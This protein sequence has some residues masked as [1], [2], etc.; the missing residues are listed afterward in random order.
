M[1][2]VGGFRGVVGFVSGWVGVGKDVV[3]VV[4]SRSRPCSVRC[5]FVRCCRGFSN[6]SKSLLL[7]AWHV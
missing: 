6:G 4:V 1:V 5:P 3:S 2:G 7:I